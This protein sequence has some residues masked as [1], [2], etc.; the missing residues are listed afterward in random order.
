MKLLN[1]ICIMLMIFSACTNNDTL[2]YRSEITIM[3]DNTEESG[4][5]YE[6]APKEELWK[7]LMPE[8]QKYRSGII[9]WVQ[10]NNVS[11]NQ[12]KTI[13]IPKENDEATRLQQK[14]VREKFMKSLDSAY[15]YFLAPSV[16][17][18]SSAIYRCV[19]RELKQLNS[20][21]ANHKILIILSDMIEFSSDADFYHVTPNSVSILV[22][23]LNQTGI[24]LPNNPKNMEV[25]ILFQ[26]KNEIMDAKFNNAMLVWGKLFTDHNISFTIKSNL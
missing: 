19:C 13:E 4:N 10:I 25:I 23:K 15:K 21:T 26:P 9:N 22:D 18:K 16:G 11:L 1:L 8:N 20:S 3:V 24:S 2:G 17:T 6:L 14:R 5:R 12:Q 7:L